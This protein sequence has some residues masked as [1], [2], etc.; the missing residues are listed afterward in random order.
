MNTQPLTA[1][2]RTLTR[3]KGVR[4]VRASGRIP[5]NIY[6][7]STTSQ[8]LEVDSK[9]FDILVHKAHSEIILVDLNISGDARPA[10][11][12]L[13]QDVHH[14]PLTGGVLHVDLHEVKPD[15]K[16]TIRVPV[17][18]VG[19]AVG[20]KTGGGVLE[21]VM[22]K[23]RVRSLPKDLPYKIEVDVS[24]LEVGKAL[25][26]SDVKAPAGVEILGDRGLSVFKVAEPVA[27]VTETP[28]AGAAEAAGEA[29]QPEM[30]KEKKEEA[31]A[32][33]AKAGDK[34]PAEKKK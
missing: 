11:L 8:N 1:F 5:A 13:V 29:K 34:K 18:S 20:V 14:D 3:R 31:P 10:R 30:I 32:A 26:L 28:A 33:D 6:G 2:P 4:A 12:A 16:V 22:L 24:S 15:E 17:E 23:V 25:H 27:E 21:H 7:K 19:E 9:E